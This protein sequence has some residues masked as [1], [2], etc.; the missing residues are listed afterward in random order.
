MPIPSRQQLLREHNVAGLLVSVLTVCFQPWGGVLQMDKAN[1]VPLDIVLVCRLC[2]VLLLY[3]F[4][5][6]KCTDGDHVSTS[7]S[8]CTPHTPLHPAAHTLELLGHP[9]KH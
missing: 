1:N 3:M 9:G 4:K 6:R 2:Y 7:S 8:L 5:V